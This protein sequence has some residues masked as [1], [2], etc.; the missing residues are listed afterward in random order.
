[1][2]VKGTHGATGP[3]LPVAGPREQVIW[4]DLECGS[5]HADL[6]L[7]RELAG[8]CAGPILEIGAGTGR[9]ALELARAGHRVTALDRDNE[10]LCA[11]EERAAEAWVETIC[12][13]ARSFE[14]S[15]HDFGLCVVAMQT[16]QLLGGAADRIAFL[17]QARAH[18]RPGGLLAC[19]IITAP[20]PFDCADGGGGPSPET[21]C[22]DGL[23][24]V[25]RAIRVQVLEQSVLIERERRIVRASEQ[26]PFRGL[27][28]RRSAGAGAAGG[29]PPW[30]EVIELDRV[31]V[32]ELERE[33]IEAGLRPCG[34]RQVA[35]TDEHAGSTVVMLRA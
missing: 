15:R 2:V 4:H 31:N 12:A 17:A 19:A 10:L 22:L 8:D 27:A 23:L 9:V 35:P 7:W 18:L 26:G 6:P 14:L 30:R 29:F 1:M 33:A 3:S 34:A 28:E 11:L 32:S 21:A 24:Y 13:D 25:S 20:E 16:I 5:Y